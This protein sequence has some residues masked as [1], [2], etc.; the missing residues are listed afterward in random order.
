VSEATQVRDPITD[1]AIRAAIADSLKSDRGATFAQV[2]SRLRV[3]VGRAIEPAEV[4]RLEAI[5]RDEGYAASAAALVSE[6]VSRVNT[7]ASLSHARP[8]VR[9]ILGLICGIA[10]FFIHLQ[11][12][13]IPKG[14]KVATSYFDLVGIAG[15]LVAI[16][17]GIGVAASIPEGQQRTIHLGLGGVILLLGVFQ[18][19]L[20]TGL[21]HQVGIFKFA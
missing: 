12:D 3:H 1:D 18:L 10:P 17:L 2:Q 13:V 14:A 9:E 8:T 19:L 5:Y 20:G 15:G 6:E 16:C 4:V 11:T 21:L 7:Q